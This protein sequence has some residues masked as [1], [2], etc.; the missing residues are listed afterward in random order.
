M[1][2]VAVCACDVG[3]AQT[4]IAKAMITDLC[5]KHGFPIEVETH[6][7]DGVQNELSKKNIED[8]DLVII[9]SNIPLDLERFKGKRMLNYKIA[10]LLLNGRTIFNNL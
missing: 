3:V 2:I 7:L 5:H 4:F 10:D 6:G 8:A 1:N 9:A